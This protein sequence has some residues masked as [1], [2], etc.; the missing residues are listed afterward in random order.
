M[1][2]SDRLPYLSFEPIGIWIEIW[3]QDVGCE[4]PMLYPSK[5]VFRTMLH[6]IMDQCMLQLQYVMI[7]TFNNELGGVPGMTKQYRS[8][9]A[10]QVKDTT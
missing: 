6:A 10:D 4:R 9:A 2:V 8:S 3:V 1:I 5:E 7:S